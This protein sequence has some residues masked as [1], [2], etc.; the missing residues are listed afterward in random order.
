MTSTYSR[1]KCGLWKV[2]I[3]SVPSA[4]G[5]KSKQNSVLS[6]KERSTI[7][8]WKAR[9][10]IKDQERSYSQKRAFAGGIRKGIMDFDKQAEARV[11]G[12][13][14]A[15]VRNLHRYFE[16]RNGASPKYSVLSPGWK[17][18]RPSEQPGR[19]AAP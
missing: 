1:S 19:M 3:T 13:E 15:K 9:Q 17:P 11:L 12:S 14:N 16:Q 10:Q 18:P 5:S 8:M 6:E 2:Y 4:L 7:T